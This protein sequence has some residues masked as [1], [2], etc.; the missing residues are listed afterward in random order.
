GG[1]RAVSGCDHRLRRQLPHQ[2]R[3]ALDQRVEVAAGQVG[4]T[5]R[6]GEQHIADEGNAVGCEGDGAGRVSGHI[7]RAEVD[8]G[9]AD[10]VAAAD[11][12]FRV[13]RGRLEAAQVV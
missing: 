4:T 9:D 1:C 8:A 11:Q 6:A 10:R 2:Q 12:V 13:V 7:E 5:D 3:D